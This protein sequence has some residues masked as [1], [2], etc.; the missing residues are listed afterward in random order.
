MTSNETKRRL[1]R[2]MN[3]RMLAG[4]CGGVATYLDVDSSIV[5]VLWALSVFL[6]GLGAVLYLV[7]ILIIPIDPYGTNA[8][9]S[10]KGTGSR[11][12]GMIF[13]VVGSLLLVDNLDIVRWSD[14]FDW[15]DILSWRFLI[16]LMMVLLGLALLFSYRRPRSIVVPTPPLGGEAE[17]VQPSASVG[18][19]MC[20]SLRDKKLFGVCGGIANHFEW[21]PALVRIGFVVL[22]FASFGVAVLLYVIL[23]F[24]LPVES[25][26]SSTS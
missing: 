14:W 6:G 10:R 7:A 2:S 16:P 11:L 25:P 9:T 4:V 1:Y 12:L 3:D 8:G 20:R 21:D 19:R 26:T 22:A 5:R 24:A 17:P 13:L 23:A 15:W 18:G